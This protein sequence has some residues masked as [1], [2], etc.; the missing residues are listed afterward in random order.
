[1]E[2]FI[3]M[4]DSE[5]P[6]FQE[7][8]IIY[9]YE[10][11]AY[12]LYSLIMIAWWITL[13]FLLRLQTFKT[14]VNQ[15]LG[16]FH[17]RRSSF[18]SSPSSLGQMRNFQISCHFTENTLFPKDIGTCLSHSCYTY[19]YFPSRL[20]PQSQ[21]ESCSWPYL[22]LVGPVGTGFATHLLQ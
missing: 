16:I 10:I 9:I 3:N 18:A 17:V 1:M 20:Y 14:R 8:S 13:R 2:N 11:F 7:T 5:V 6:L 15:V 21:V 12:I 4:D 22:G 19:I